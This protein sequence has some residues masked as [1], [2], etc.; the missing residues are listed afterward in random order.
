MA[1]GSITFHHTEIKITT[2]YRHDPGAI[3]LAVTDR[4]SAG[5]L[6][7]TETRNILG[8]F[9]LRNTNTNTDTTNQH[10]DSQGH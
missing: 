4:V 5:V 2:I 3:H 10:H 7:I 9:K 8:Y 1:A 6:I